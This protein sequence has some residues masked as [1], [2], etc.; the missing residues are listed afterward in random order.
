MIIGC[1]TLLSGDVYEAD[2][3]RQRALRGGRG[4]DND[5]YAKRVYFGFFLFWS[6][7]NRG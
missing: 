6:R 7:H 4:H 3:N 2:D 1:G 5:L